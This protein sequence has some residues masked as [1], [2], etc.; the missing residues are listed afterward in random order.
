MND[1]IA[2]AVVFLLIAAVIGFFAY[3]RPLYRSK[4]KYMLD[5]IVLVYRNFIHWNI[6]KLVI[7]VYSWLL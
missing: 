1:T 4:L 7:Y 5:N 3:R 6:S 2:N